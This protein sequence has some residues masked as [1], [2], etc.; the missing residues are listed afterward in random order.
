[1]A[2]IAVDPDGNAV[3]TGRLS[4]DVLLAK[5]NPAGQSVFAI[6]FGGQSSDMA[7]DIALGADRTLFLTGMTLSKD[8]DGSEEYEGFPYWPME[9]YQTA[10]KSSGDAFVCRIDAS[11]PNN[12][13]FVY[14]TYLGGNSF[15]MEDEGRAI[16]ADAAG[17]AYVAGITPS[18]DFPTTES[19][20]QRQAGGH[21]T[22]AFLAKISPD[23]TQ[24]LYGTYMGGGFN[25]EA[26]GVAA[27]NNGNAY[28]TG[29]TN[30]YDCP[31]TPNSFQPEYAIGDC[32]PSPTGTLPCADAFV[33]K[34]DTKQSGEA[35]FA[36]STFLGGH[37]S[38]YGYGITLDA[39]GNAYVVGQTLPYDFPLVNELP[40]AGAGKD[41][42]VAKLDPTGKNLLFSTTFGG[43]DD[44]KG[45]AVA[46]DTDRNIYVVGQT[47]STTTFP[48]PGAVQADFGGGY[49]DAF[50]VKITAGGSVPVA[51]D[52]DGNGQ[53]TIEDVKL[54]L[55][56][57]G[58]FAAATADQVSRGEAAAP[59]GALTL[60]DVA[61][62]LRK[63]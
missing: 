49:R 51:G 30:S 25:E 4:M 13:I 17:N 47:S 52:V 27:D 21:L 40:D 62:L 42:F 38:D 9:A 61:A 20:R 8:Y 7:Y 48:R 26:H 19:G 23:G 60:A 33:V 15:L 28:V 54:S 1:V 11:D 46:L 3:L 29:W 43:A 34:V 44:D 31:T 24:L 35:S 32:D 39:D 63:L 12:L 5:L 53:F 37:F 59:S 50:V 45:N 56:I 18:A 55:R 10:R 22:D 58:G 14:S 57:A 2:G 16:A 41:V 36:Y 6:A